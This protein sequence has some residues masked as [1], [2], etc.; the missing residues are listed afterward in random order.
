[1]FIVAT[2]R[3]NIKYKVGFIFINKLI[4]GNFQHLTLNVERNLPSYLFIEFSCSVSSRIEY[5]LAAI[6]SSIFNIIKMKEV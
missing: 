2:L 5:I 4:T 1:M 3:T 6:I